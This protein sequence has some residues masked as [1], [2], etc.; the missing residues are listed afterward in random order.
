MAIDA[1]GEAEECELPFGEVE[2]NF[3]FESCEV[4]GD[5]YKRHESGFW[6]KRRRLSSER[7]PVCLMVI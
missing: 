6:G 7:R 4:L 5:R 3:W 2:Y 1:G